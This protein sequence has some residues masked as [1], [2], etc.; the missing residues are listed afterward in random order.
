MSRLQAAGAPIS[1]IAAPEMR[2]EGRR[3]AFAGTL[4]RYESRFDAVLAKC[5]GR[6][7][8]DHRDA[9]GGRHRPACPL[10]QRVHAVRRGQSQPPIHRELRRSSLERSRVGGRYELEKWQS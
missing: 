7:S 8:A 6:S 4:S 9:E 10:E 3:Q 2:A 1:V 5:V